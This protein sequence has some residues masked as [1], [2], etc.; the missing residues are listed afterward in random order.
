M[1]S[2]DN[3]K[4]ELNELSIKYLNKF[5]ESDEVI[6]LNGLKDKEAFLVAFKG[7]LEFADMIMTAARCSMTIDGFVEK[8]AKLMESELDKHEPRS[9]DHQ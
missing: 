9:C 5:V 7:P 3:K 4:H 1:N 6:T 8:F 2:I